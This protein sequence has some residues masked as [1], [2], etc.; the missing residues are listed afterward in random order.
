MNRKGFFDDAIETLTI[1][2]EAL[3]PKHYNDLRPEKPSRPPQPRQAPSVQRN[4]MMPCQA[5]RYSRGRN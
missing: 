4:R 5:R 1:L 3:H 2:V